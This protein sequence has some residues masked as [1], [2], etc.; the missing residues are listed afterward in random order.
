MLKKCLMML[1][2]LSAIVT[3]NATNQRVDLQ[4]NPDGTL[5]TANHCVQPDHSDCA[6][7]TTGTLIYNANPASLPS[8]VG[9]VQNAAYSENSRAHYS[10]TAASTCTLGFVTV[11]GVDAATGGW[12]I[13]GSNLQNA[14]T[15][16][17]SGGTIRESCTAGSNPPVLGPFRAWSIVPTHGTD[18]IAPNPVTGVTAN[19]GN[20]SIVAAW[21][22]TVDPNVNRTGVTAYH[23]R[24]NGTTID[25]LTASNPGAIV[26]L[27]GLNLGG[28]SGTCTPSGAQLTITGEGAGIDGTSDNAFACV[29]SITAGSSGVDIAVNLSSLTTPAT[30]NKLALEF[31]ASDSPDAAVFNC[32]ALVSGGIWSMQS[33]D[34]LTTGGVRTSINGTVALSAKPNYVYAHYD[35][36][37]AIGNCNHSQDGGVWS[38]DL[39]GISIALPTILRARIVVTA[40]SD[41]TSITAVLPWVTINNVGRLT[42]SVSVPAGGAQY[43]VTATDG[44]NESTALASAGATP[45]GV[46]A[47]KWHA[48]FWMS[49]PIDNTYGPSKPQSA[50]FGV[51]DSIAN[52]SMIVGAVAA[53]RWSDLEG[54]TAGDYIAGFAK[55]HAEINKLKGLA[56]P[57]RFFLRIYDLNYTSAGQ[58]GAFPQYVI[59]SGLIVTGGAGGA[60]YWCR[61]N[62]GMMDHYIAMLQ[63]YAAEF[64]SED[65]FEG[66]YLIAETAM[67]LPA[68]PGCGYSSAAFRAQLHRMEIAAAAAFQKS[69]VV[70]SISWLVDSQSDTD[71]YAASMKTVPVGFGAPDILPQFLAPVAC[72]AR[73]PWVYKS[74]TGSSGGHD[75]RGEL[76]IIYNSEIDIYAGSLGNCTVAQV[77][78]YANNVLH[79]SHVFMAYN[80]YAGT[81]AQRWSTGIKPYIDDP[82]NALSLNNRQ[83]PSAYT[84][85]CNI[86]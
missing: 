50:R 69:N 59:D 4:P 44:S 39:S 80:Y 53:Y 17:S 72:S 66:L 21:D 31:V 86:F 9:L 49:M 5:S 24:R 29:M 67:N 43:S 25:T 61:W 22:S 85:G 73:T 81:A 16:T 30:I 8:L 18:S 10:G 48:G 6:P 45:N 46:P 33:R 13:S 76:P 71:A 58:R 82:N 38:T 34:R 40:N 19:P 55:L 37:T 3:S 64:D 62:S 11:S 84:Q 79:A 26:S 56:V 27:S 65:Y 1:V 77:R 2:L 83:C 28:G 32:T 35:P 47:K 41:G 36:A 60:E 7:P 12:I 75:Y 20:N 74:I 14:N 63:A 68:S 52:D 54:P 70:E 42:K 23:I 57:K 51:Y 78:D 15:S